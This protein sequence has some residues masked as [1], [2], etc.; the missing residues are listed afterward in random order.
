MTKNDGGPAFPVSQGVGGS[1]HGMTLRDY[2]AAAAMA[3]VIRA[4]NSQADEVVSQIVKRGGKL[5]EKD[6]EE[7][8]LSV[9]EGV[10][11]G[12]YAIADAMLAERAK[13]WDCSHCCTTVPTSK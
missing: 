4:K 5:T 7:F 1:I 12:C 6:A 13:W 10:A 11:A 8:T 2:F 9:A 3:E